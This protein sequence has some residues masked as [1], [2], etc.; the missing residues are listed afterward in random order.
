M[1]WCI[2]QADP[3][4]RWALVRCKLNEILDE[5]FSDHTD[6]LTQRLQPSRLASVNVL[7]SSNPWWAAAKASP[8][9][10]TSRLE[11]G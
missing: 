11:A 4:S 3:E 8:A 2:Y 10:S 5:T 6:I 1:S 7:H 9:V